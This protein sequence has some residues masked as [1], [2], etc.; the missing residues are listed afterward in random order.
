MTN[1]FVSSVSYRIYS[2]ENNQYIIKVATGLEICISEIV[3]S[4]KR[5][6]RRWSAAQLQKADFLIKRLFCSPS[7]VLVFFFFIFFSLFVAI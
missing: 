2:C 4:V 1:L 7:K 3:H 6:Q 5:K